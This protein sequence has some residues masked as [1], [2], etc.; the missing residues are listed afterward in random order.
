MLD[1]RESDVF[2]LN[3]LDE[4][5]KKLFKSVISSSDF[6]VI[7]E[8]LYRNIKSEIPEVERIVI[9]GRVKHLSK[10]ETLVLEVDEHGVNERFIVGK[11]K[12]EGF[13]YKEDL[14]TEETKVGSIYIFARRLPTKKLEFFRLLFKHIKYALAVSL[15][16]EISYELLE[17]EKEE[18]QEQVV[19]DP[20]TKLHNRTYLFDFLKR[21]VKNSIKLGFPVSLAVIDID[22]FKE[23][24]DTHGHLVGDCVLR[25][26]A[27]ILKESF[28][29][30][31]CVARYGGE[32]FVVVLPF[33]SLKYACKKLEEV[34]KTIE[35][36]RFCGK[37]KL[38]LTI[39]V[40]VTEYKR[41]EPIKRFLKR[42]DKNLYKAKNSGRNKVVCE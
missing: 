34:R 19:I 11:L 18:L 10:K 14:E 42:A 3:K 37:K 16:R 7:A 38:R 41:N 8:K 40:G 13:V 24:N 32:E 31:D 6:N 20:L 4:I 17:R 35:Q 2:V 28:R 23:V 12:V 5:L 26:L 30:S 33:S 25:E 39:S 9:V 15:E 27:S 22:F 29:S 36:H 1:D 21:T